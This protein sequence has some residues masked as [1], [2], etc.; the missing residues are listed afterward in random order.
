MSGVQVAVH[1][2]HI[3]PQQPDSATI[4]DVL[5]RATKGY[6]I[7][8]F[9]PQIHLNFK[10]PAA[11][12]SFTEL[13]LDKPR[14]APDVCYTEPFQLFSEEGVRV[15]RRE[16][17]RKEF[18]DK[19]MRSWSR[20][21]CYIGGHS[22]N[23]EE[24]SFIKQAWYHPATQAAIDEAFGTGLKPLE[25]HCDI[26]Y[27]NVQLGEGGTAGVYKY[28]EIPAKPQPPSKAATGISKSQWDDVP[29]DGWHKDQVPVVCV[30]MLSDISNM[31]GGETAIRTGQGNLIKARG[32]NLGGAVLMQGGNLEHAALRASNCSERVSMVTSYCFANPDLDDSR[33]TLKS[34][35]FENEDMNALKYAHLDYKLK[36]LRDRV[37][38][39]CERVARQRA[40]NAELNRDEID[41]WVK[42]QVGFLKQTSWELFE[43]DESLMGLEMPDG[44]LRDYLED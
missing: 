1:P 5:P 42:E 11:R 16:I 10:P 27:A 22:A 34:A 43:R 17:F 36:R 35:D 14:N 24:A 25:R 19:Y 23:S 3:T 38:L 12:Y 30:V 4:K 7:P 9:D 21:P 15:M 13:G 28:N 2:V 44:I 18:L 39:A 32:A 26:G 40:G 31:Q 20:A 6:N 29:I 33:T 41:G 8:R 37:N